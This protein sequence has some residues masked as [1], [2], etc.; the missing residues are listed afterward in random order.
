MKHFYLH[1]LRCAFVLAGLLLGFAM[2]AQNIEKTTPEAVGLDAHRLQHADACIDKAIREGR[3]PG[4]VLAV[5]RH[6]KIGYLKAYGRR[7]TLPSPLPMTENT[8]FDMASCTKSMATTMAVMQ[9]LEQ[10]KLR[11]NDPVQ[12]YLPH[13][14]NW[15]EGQADSVVIRIVHLLTHTSGLP[16]Y[17][18]VAD[19]QKK[20]RFPD[21]E[22]QMNYIETCR[23]N[24]KPAC[25]M[26]YSCLNF[27]TLQHIVE[28]ITGQSLRDYC[29]EHVFQPLHMRHTDFIPCA[30]NKQGFWV[31][32][33]KP[34]WMKR[35]EKADDT[36]LAPTEKQPNGQIL[37][38]IVHDPLAR[39]MNGGI[40]GNAGLFSNAEDVAV[41]CAMLL[42]G[43]SWQGQQILSPL[44]VE[45]MQQ[46]P[47]GFEA[48]GRC[49]GWDKS[50][51][52]ASNKGDLL[53]DAAFGHT[54]Y[55]GTSIVIDPKNDLAIILLTNAVHPID[56]TNVVRLR[57]E[58]AN[59]VAGSVTQ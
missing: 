24:E 16:A 26:Q 19:L 35:G 20:G 59:A 13:F 31:E 30:P 55:T 37:C 29:A 8:I 10:G 36:P 52:Y 44:T 4:A 27:I 43:G 45:K 1:S 41:L 38:G 42:N 39:V 5:V 34:R 17:A 6:G 14:Q 47:A 21:A 46:I 57:A 2:S 49:L 12:L 11:L 9:L 28:Q 18:P 15:K 58:V 54:G 32:T 56:K 33:D 50:S 23:R 51:P 40:S 25:D 7:Q 48:F 53:S 22:R 3:T